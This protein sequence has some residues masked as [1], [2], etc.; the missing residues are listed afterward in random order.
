LLADRS[1]IASTCVAL[2]ATL[3]AAVGL[4]VERWLFF[5]EATHVSMLYY[6]RAP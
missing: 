1:P 5:A 3:S 2:L 6:G 4:G